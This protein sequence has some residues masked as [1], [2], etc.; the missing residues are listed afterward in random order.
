MSSREGRGRH[1]VEIE[2]SRRNN[3]L[4]GERQTNR[5]RKRRMGRQAEGAGRWWE[6]R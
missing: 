5:E 3:E 6:E 1:Y 4:E 2:R